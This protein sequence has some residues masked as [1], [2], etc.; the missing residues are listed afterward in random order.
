MRN[1]IDCVRSRKRD[2]LTA[3]I[4][5][6]VRSAAFVHLGNVSYRVGENVSFDEATNA[7][8]GNK[9][10]G[11]AFEGIKRHLTATGR[12]TLSDTPCR[13]G[14]TLTFDAG[15]GQFVD[16]PDA[17]KLLDRA[18]RGPFVVPEKV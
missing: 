6:G 7:V 2:D 18:Y 13:L 4:L 11:E 16:A 12:V 10:L 8:G 14:R 3:E 15:A 1:F 17:N 9:M 5:E